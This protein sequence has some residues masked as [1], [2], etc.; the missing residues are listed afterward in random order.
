MRYLGLCGVLGPGGRQRRERR[1]CYSAKCLLAKNDVLLGQCTDSG[2]CESAQICTQNRIH[3]RITR[4][5]PVVT[6]VYL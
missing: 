4:H 5:R 2:V 3:H 1:N 6:G